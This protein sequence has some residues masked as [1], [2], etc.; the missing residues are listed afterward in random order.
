[1]LDGAPASAMMLRWRS[2]TDATPTRG[3]PR[4][5]AHEPRWPH[6]AR[7]ARLKANGRHCREHRAGTQLATR[8]VSFNTARQQGPV[9]CPP[10]HGVVHAAGTAHLPLHDRLLRSIEKQSGR[11]TGH[12]RP[13]YEEEDWCLAHCGRL[14]ASFQQLAGKTPLRTADGSLRLVHGQRGKQTRT[15]IM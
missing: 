8:G 5:C 3:N 9:R 12:L 11:G 2:P 13:S 14:V 10:W 6:P 1:M 7:G 15:G 4:G